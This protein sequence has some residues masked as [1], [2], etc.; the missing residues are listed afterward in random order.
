[1]EQQVQ[2]LREVCKSTAAEREASKDLLSS[3][4]VVAAQSPVAMATQAVARNTAM[5]AG[6][7]LIPPMPVKIPTELD[8]S[9]PPNLL[10]G[11]TAQNVDKV[12]GN[13]MGPLTGQD[14]G[15]P[16]EHALIHS[17]QVPSEEHSESEKQRWINT[18]ALIPNSVYSPPTTK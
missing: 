12:S 17:E 18:K 16:G 8:F 1:M 6:T 11:S 2:D 4:A 7:D 15:K 5:E 3:S 9:L 13:P 10:D 14:P